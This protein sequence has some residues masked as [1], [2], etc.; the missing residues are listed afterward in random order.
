[1]S[2]KQT[3]IVSEP[4]KY[5]ELVRKLYR[6]NWFNPVNLG[7]HNINR[8]HE[9]LGHPMDREH[10]LLVHV[11]GTNGKGSVCNKIARTLTLAGYNTGLY[12]SPHIS[13]FRER[14][15][16]NS[17]PIPEHDVELYMPT[18]YDLA[19]SH[20]IPATFFEITTALA[21]AY[22]DANKVDA[23]VLETGL[24]GT[25][26]A[27]N[28]VKCPSLT[29]ITS[30]G[31][32]HTKI[33][34]D[35]IELI[36]KEKAGIIKPHCPVLVGPN[37]P[38][39]V[40]RDIAKANESEYFVSDH[41]LATNT[42]SHCNSSNGFYDYSSLLD[43]DLENS[44]I[45]QAAIQLLQQ[46]HHPNVSVSESELQKGISIRPPCRFEEITI[47]ANNAN[48]TVI[49]DIAHNPAALKL[50]LSKLNQT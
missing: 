18:I 41:V 14:I 11:A 25:L 12:T 35:T 21:F 20:Q 8:L 28:V 10:L 50:L 43:F 5:E 2:T 48:V 36:A 9:L 33:L 46:K 42:T 38:H 45:A 17:S 6:T 23:V 22:F 13:S 39:D 27:T 49:L 32:D 24:G 34:G 4:T 19:E 40:I 37:V 15:Q 29:I 44:R 31:L 47:Q 1:M 26:D 30:I 7:L 16:L 3:T